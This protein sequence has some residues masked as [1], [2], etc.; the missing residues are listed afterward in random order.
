[1]Q[2]RKL[3]IITQVVGLVV[4]I[5]VAAGLTGAMGLFGMSRMYHD[6]VDMNQTEIIPMD[7]L[8]DLRH[9]TQAYQADVFMLLESSQPEQQKLIQELNGID[10]R[11]QKNVAELPKVLQPGQESQLLDQFKTTWQSYTQNAKAVVATAETQQTAEAKALVNQKLDELSGQ[12]SGLADKL[13]DLK[14]ERVL[15]GRMASHTQIYQTG[16]TVATVVMGAAILAAILLGWGLGRS[17]KR[18]MQN[19]VAEAQAI[20]SGKLQTG[21]LANMKTFNREGEELQRALQEMTVSLHTMVEEVQKTS[22]ELAEVALNVRAGMEDSTRAAEQVA[23]AAG[24]IANATANQVQE[25]KTNQGHVA[26][27]LAQVETAQEKTRTVS[28]SAGHSAELARN[29][30]ESLNHAVKQMREIEQQVEELAQVVAEVEG[31]SQSIAATVQIIESIAQQTNLLALNAAIEAARA[32]ENGRGFAVVA[33]E[34]RKLAEQVQTSLTEITM[35]VTTMQQTAQ[36]AE[37][38]MDMS[39]KSVSQGSAVLLEISSQFEAI[40]TAVEQSAELSQ[41]IA[42]FVTEVESSS[43]SIMSGMRSVANQAE[44]AAAQTQTTAAAAEEQNASI[45]EMRAVS[46]TLSE[47]AERLKALVVRFE[48]REAGSAD[49]KPD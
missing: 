28:D 39:R 7:H 26:T 5:A 18:L 9:D 8:Q 46:E 15:H 3:S 34:V 49:L 36:T 14:L 43:Q 44:E 11:V 47:Y 40:L 25:M 19:L 4:I 27:M 13:Y 23:V 30:R 32:G 33:E 24:E 41:D 1:M 2:K 29:G 48:I 22:G 45:E 6:M 16:M 20:A 12:A 38:G 21:R 37:R 35:S 10:Q 31:Q 42:Y 17:L